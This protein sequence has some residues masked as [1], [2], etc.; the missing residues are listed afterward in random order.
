MTDERGDPPQGDPSVAAPSN[1][2]PLRWGARP[3][4]WAVLA[5][6][7]G[8]RDDLL[9]VVSNPN[10][11]ISPQSKMKGV[12]KTPSRYNSFGHAA[13]F[14]RWPEHRA[15]DSDIRAWQAQPDYGVCIQTRRLRG[16]DIDVSDQAIVDQILELVGEALDQKVFETRQRSNSAKCLWPV[17]VDDPDDGP[18][19]KR[20]LILPDN[21]GA[22]EFLATGQQFIACGTHPSGSRYHWGERSPVPTMEPHRLE[23]EEFEA[24]WL[25]LKAHLGAEE[26]RSEA[27]KPRLEALSDAARA[28]HVAAW[29]YEH[30]RVLDVGRDG[31]L[32]VECPNAAEHTTDTGPTSTA[33]YPAFTGG[34]QQGHWVCLHAHCAGKPDSFFT[35]L[36]G[37]IEFEDLTADA[38]RAAAEIRFDDLSGDPAAP[39]HPDA[40]TGAE[41][42]PD[43]DDD[44]PV[45]KKTAQFRPRALGEFL[46]SMS[47]EAWCVKHVLPA[48][49]LV[50]LFGESGAGKSFTV[51][52]IACHIALGRTWQGRRVTQNR[53]VYLA[54]EGQG[55]I[56]KRFKAW[57][58]HHEVDPTVLPLQV[59]TARPNFLQREDVVALTRAIGKAGVVVI[60]T[61]M[62]VTP[63]ADENSAEDMGKLM[64]FAARVAASVGGVVL[65]VHHSGKDASRGQRGWS[66]LKGAVDTELEVTRAGD[67]R[68]LRLSK[69]RDGPLEG[70]CWHFDLRDVVLGYD[71]EGDAINSAVPVYREVAARAPR[72]P[73]LSD[74]QELIV[75]TASDLIALGEEVSEEDVVRESTRRIP[76]PDG[77]DIRRQS[78]KKSI[79]RL[80]RMGVLLFEDDV[81]R[82]P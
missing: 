58:Q 3:E 39:T 54:A 18:L 16:L 1:V 30:G 28:D 53:V 29:L 4:D 52:D 61:A 25:R 46:A 59:I 79:V 62:A 72:G 43:P 24:L 64:D 31:Q 33:Y 8:L 76:V 65:I 71:A 75:R 77:R 51:I 63:G 69:V 38:E 40:P 13:G 36:L 27:S 17:W 23:L 73:K 7:L 20:R 60:D 14:P 2:I 50:T 78:V 6:E 26:G 57:C 48:A 68:Q 67:A 22:I 82:L 70:F 42:M 80:A 66:G 45:A 44:S 49:G 41:P 74:L 55:G 32:F 15:T 47:T 21:A 11:K 10:A 37:M 12:G 56:A 34:Y 5:T 81:V 19:T 35:N 9:P